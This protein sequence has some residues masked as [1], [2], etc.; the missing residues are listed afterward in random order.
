MS[1]LQVRH[2]YVHVP[3]CTR[4]CAYCDFAV[5]VSRKPSGE[6][7]VAAIRRELRLL[8]ESGE[9][10]LAP[11]L[12]T[13]YLGGG[14]PSVLPPHRV[15]ELADI[16]GRDRLGRSQLEWTAEANPE[17]FTAATARGVGGRPRKPG[18]A[19]RAEL[20]HGRPPV[21]GTAA[22]GRRRQGRSWR[23]TP[24]RHQQPVRRPNLWTARHR[25]QELGGRLE[26]GSTA[27]RAAHISLYGLTVEKGTP[28]AGIFKS[29][30]RRGLLT[31][32]YQDEYPPRGRIPCLRW[33]S[34]LRTCPTLHGRAMPRGT[35][36][37][38]GRACHTWDWGTAPTAFTEGADCGTKEAGWPMRT[39]SPKAAGAQAAKP[40][41]QSKP[42][43]K[44]CGWGSGLRTAS[45]S[46]NWVRRRWRWRRDGRPGAWEYAMA[47]G[48]ALRPP[49]GFSWTS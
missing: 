8:R 27:G 26:T 3:F 6:R 34:S 17:S 46:A 25:S 4:R 10:T 22:H 5:E 13:L 11:K 15:S 19:W 16:V 14:T 40:C 38:T 41:R 32:R 45:I 9:V 48:F 18:I 42:G 49:A 29:S 30:A 1:T 2:L 43:W 20:R 12:D 24:G 37:R 33:V 7:W 39:K 31:G 35:T 21:A 36:G 23:S 47:G 44:V 28:L